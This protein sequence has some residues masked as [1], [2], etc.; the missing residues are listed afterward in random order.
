MNPLV[1]QPRS[2][3]HLQCKNNLKQIMLAL[4]NYHDD[5]GTFPPAYTVDENGKRMHSWRTLIWPYL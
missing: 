2:S 5:F 4:H 3:R 1:S